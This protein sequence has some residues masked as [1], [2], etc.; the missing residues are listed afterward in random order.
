MLEN[1]IEEK[2]TTK[3]EKDSTSTTKKTSVKVQN[4]D[5]TTTITDTITTTKHLN[6]IKMDPNA[7]IQSYKVEATSED[8]R[9]VNALYLK[10]EVAI[11]EDNNNLVCIIPLNS[12]KKI[13]SL[14]DETIEMS[15]DR[16]SYG[17]YSIEEII[18]FK[19]LVHYHSFNKNENLK[20][21]FQLKNDTA[22]KFKRGSLNDKQL[23]NALLFYENMK[24]GNN[25]KLNK[26]EIDKKKREDELRLKVKN[27]LEI[28]KKKKENEENI[29]R[30][31]NENKVKISKSDEEKI[32]MKLRIEEENRK[33]EEERQR[34]QEIEK[35][36]QEEIS[37]RQ[38]LI[39][40]SRKKDI[41]Q[42]TKQM[43][44]EQN[45]SVLN[46]KKDESGFTKLRN[47]TKEDTEHDE[48][49]AQ[50]EI[51]RE[52]FE[53]FKKNKIEP[54]KVEENT[55]ISVDDMSPLK[56]E[57]NNDGVVNSS[58]LPKGSLDDYI[59]SF[60][61]DKINDLNL[62]SILGEDFFPTIPE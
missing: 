26:N 62:D 47:E 43:L 14:F 54:S 29:K 48:Y 50:S 16:V 30:E 27:Q 61:D 21:D 31:K 8:K 18:Q 45:N 35:R 15:F 57:K 38:K 3:K 19:Q 56:E 49:I 20:K 28:I 24:N 23:N 41:E 13:F 4:P 32:K 37:K 34:Q 53:E 51:E 1:E 59:K 33:K 60:D 40:E 17:I 2:K 52:L 44:E 36:R 42:R 12:L 22:K 58:D 11:I 5:G 9:Y 39:E 25:D 55:N 6:K 7:Q 46:S 10:N